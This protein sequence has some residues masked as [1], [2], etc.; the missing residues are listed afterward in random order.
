VKKQVYV[1]LERQLI[2][3]REAQHKSHDGKQNSGRNPTRLN[4]RRK[5]HAFDTMGT[6]PRTR[7][8]GT[9]DTKLFS[10]LKAITEYK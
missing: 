1:S 6:E 7:I 3:L 9:L 8:H 5:S 10:S 4:Y 2:E